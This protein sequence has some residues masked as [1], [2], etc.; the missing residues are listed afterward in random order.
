M[1]SIFRFPGGK[2]RKS[3][4][5]R[6]LSKSPP[7]FKEYREPFVGGGGIYF[8]IPED[9]DR[10]INDVDVNLIL[11]YL[12]LSLRPEGFISKC[13]SILPPQEGEA[14]TSA[15]P[16]GKQ[17]YS[18]R[19]KEVFDAFS[20]DQEMDQALRYF[21]VNRT[22]WGGR[23]N[24]DLPSRMYFSNPTGWNIVNTGKLEEAAE[25][26]KN[27]MVTVGSYEPLLSR[28]GED[29]WIYCDPPYVVNTDLARS[30]QLYRY[31]F[32][33]EQ[34]EKFAE[35]VKRCNHK[36]C[37]SYDDNEVVRDLFKD[38]NIDEE[39]WAYCG[40]SSAEG[41]SKTKKQG[42]ELLITNY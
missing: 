10:W 25:L 22:V 13:Q 14:L 33:F 9:I 41:C 8:A 20:F 12:A 21:F 17:I 36:V 27:T 5:N 31:G 2:T 15:R 24:Y 6:I 23:V 34:H 39:E 29:V 4:R 1:Q 7:G 3:V 16:G 18:K 19:L 35:D 38:F 26:L 40:T 30:S 32:T 37:I 28:P 11:V 42:K